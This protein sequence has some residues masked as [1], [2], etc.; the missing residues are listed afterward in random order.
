MHNN[1]P[2]SPLAPA[3]GI[4]FTPKL[5]VIMACG[6]AANSITSDGEVYCGECF[7][8]TIAAFTPADIPNVFRFA[9]CMDC[10]CLMES[11]PKTLAFF[12]YR[13]DHETDR[14]WCGCRH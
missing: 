10:G 1:T 2:L 6:H 11:K 12:T 8:E 4:S 13:D 9:E 3:G 14:F 5:T 7:G